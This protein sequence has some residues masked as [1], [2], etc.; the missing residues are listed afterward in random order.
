MPENYDYSAIINHQIF[1]V[2]LANSRQESVASLRDDDFAGAVSSSSA[3]PTELQSAASKTQRPQ[4]A[5]PT[6]TLQA[7]ET[8][9]A[10]SKSSIIEE[11]I[12]G[13]DKKMIL[14]HI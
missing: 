11:S 14:K 4:T 12:A 3:S 13:N 1:C 8:K 6:P 5:H 7:T 2:G 10:V 9:S